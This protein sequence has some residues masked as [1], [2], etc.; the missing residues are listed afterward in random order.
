VLRQ[1]GLVNIERDVSDGRWVYYS[2]NTQ[3]LEELNTLFGAFFD[4]Q[5]IQPR[6]LTCGP[7]G[8][9]IRLDNIT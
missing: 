8:E 1:A 6:R 5:R 3:A 9:F 4:R 2:I 7:Q